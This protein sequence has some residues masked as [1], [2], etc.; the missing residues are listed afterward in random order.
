MFVYFDVDRT[1]LDFDTAAEL[2]IKNVFDEFRS[3]IKTNF[4]E[5]IFQWKKWAQFYFD[6]YSEGKWTH[7][8]QKR[9]RLWKTFLVT[10]GIEL[11]YEEADRRFA[12]YEKV[13]EENIALFSDV[14]PVLENLK[15]AGVPMGVITN[16][17]EPIQ[18][19]KL[20]RF[21]LKKYF[22]VVVVS[23]SAGVSKPDPEIGRIAAEK[24]GNPDPSEIYFVGD[25]LVHDIPLALALGWNGVFINRRGKKYEVPEGIMEIGNLQEIVP[26]ITGSFQK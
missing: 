1:L 4:E 21:G 20:E 23:S 6:E 26:E 14:I 8:E 2:G 9:M 25:S 19:A 13:Y 16:G 18:L 7:W 12:F 5:F 11:S 15:Q 17:E 3:D 10:G 22:D 24:I